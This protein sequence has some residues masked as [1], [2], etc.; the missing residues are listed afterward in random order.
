MLRGEPPAQLEFFDE[1]CRRLKL[2]DGSPFELYPEQRRMLADYFS[3][4]KETLIL[5]PKKN[6]KT[7]LLA[8]L[9]LFHLTVTD[10]AACFIGASSKDQ[11]SILY[12]QAQGFVNRSKWLQKHV[13]VRGGT[14]EIRSARD[15]GSL[16]VL[17][18]DA[19][20]ADGVIPTL[21]LVDELH[22]HKNS[23]LYAVFRDGLGPRAGQ[24]ITIST[25]G[26]D[27][28]SPLGRLRQ[29]AHE[30]ADQVRE[31]SYRY[32]RKDGFALHEWA[33]APED[34]RDDLELVKTANPAP[35]QTVGLLR[36]RKESP[37]MRSWEWARFACGLW[38]FGEES[39]VSEKEWREC[40]DPDA[41]IE[42][43]TA[44]VIVGIDLG[45]KWDTTAIVPVLQDKDTFVVH[46]PTIVV[47]PRDGTS[48]PM[49]DIWEPIAEMAAKWPEVTF[50]LDPEA[51]GEQL[52]QRI[53]SELPSSVVA[54]HSQKASPMA[55]AA[56]RLSDAIAEGR[57]RHPDDPEMNQQVLAA[58]AKPV[59]EGF[60][61]TKH[62][63]KP[64][65]VDSIIALAMAVSVSHEEPEVPSQVWFT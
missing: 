19:D 16:R 44:G 50:V 9:G 18:A 23:D 29:A 52:A 21:A 54:T 34:D 24:M 15:L 48:T 14:R 51:G 55:L 39:A 6:G 41:F 40:A 20:T 30:I 65:A 60:R 53:D 25:A 5:I 17:A 26:D 57:L 56:Q 13:V 31:G 47:P 28:N 4:A 32:A 42:D 37:S 33:L 62:R 38:V 12:R 61:F 8:A 3:G 27:E 36:E 45:W 2:E 46:P 10:D 49:E 64:K 59:G 7:T 63:K 58:A 22:R 11:A 43:G 1:F 35:W